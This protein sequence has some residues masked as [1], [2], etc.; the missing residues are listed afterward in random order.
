MC[1]NLCIY[2]VFYHQLFLFSCI[3]ILLRKILKDPLS[4]F[5][6]Y[7]KIEINYIQI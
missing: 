3:Y 6:I 4:S 1:L 2:N 5:N 7:K